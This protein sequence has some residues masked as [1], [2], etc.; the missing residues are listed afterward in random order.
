MHIDTGCLVAALRQAPEE[1]TFFPCEVSEYVVEHIFMPLRRDETICF[2]DLDFD[3]FD[4]SDIQ[5]L[6]DWIEQ[7]GRMAR[8]LTGLSRVFCEAEPV[9]APLRA[10]C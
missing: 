6:V 1:Q 8:R 3:A 2:T 9:S 5:G 4:E 7:R 10:F